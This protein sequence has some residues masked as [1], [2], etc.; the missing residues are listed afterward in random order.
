MQE[1]ATFAMCKHD[2]AAPHINQRASGNLDHISRPHG[3]QHAFAPNLQP[4][5]SATA[6]SLCRQSLTLRT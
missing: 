5:P 3:G 2:F 4:Q 1:E 6:Q